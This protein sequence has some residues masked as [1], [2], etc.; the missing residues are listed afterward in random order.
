[1]PVTTMFSFITGVIVKTG[2]W[3]VPILMLAE[4]LVPVIPS[5]IILPMAGFRL[6]A[7]NSILAATW[8]A[9]LIWAGYPLSACYDA[10]QH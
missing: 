7:D 8:S 2:V 9:L 4:N 6:R 1:M 10:V 3:A 5:E